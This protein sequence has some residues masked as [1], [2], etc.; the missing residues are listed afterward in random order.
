MIILAIGLLVAAMLLC[1]LEIIVT[2]FGAM[3]ALAV[4]CAIGSCWAAFRQDSTSGWV[5]IA[6]NI[7]GMV[8]AFLIS[9]RFFSKRLAL[10]KSQTEEGGYV[11]VADL[12]NLVGKIGVAFT[13]LRPGGTAVI[14][15]RK[16]DVVAS[17]GFIEPNTR[18]RV[19]FVEGVKVVVERETL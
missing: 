10:P 17:G 19:L 9:L 6:L 1:F 18:V 12:S 16:I 8:T 3:T 5:F 2:S 13:P 4:C 7:V 15:D 11:P 14:E